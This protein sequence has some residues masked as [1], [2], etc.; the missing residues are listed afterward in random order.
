MQS[1]RYNIRRY[2]SDTSTTQCFDPMGTS[3][4]VL[5]N[6]LVQRSTREKDISLQKIFPIKPFLLL[7]SLSC[8]IIPSAD[9]TPTPFDGL[10]ADLEAALNALLDTLGPLLGLTDEQVKTIEA[11]IDTLIKDLEAVEHGEIDID[12]GLELV[13]QDLIKILHDFGVESAQEL[14][15]EVTSEFKSAVIIITVRTISTSY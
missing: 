10:L 9:E 12:G 14:D 11:D 6:N 3:H 5:T 15:M 2:S 4:I 1:T 8:H 7:K 13:V